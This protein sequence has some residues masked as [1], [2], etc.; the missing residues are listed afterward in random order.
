M[1][2]WLSR[3]ISKIAEAVAR[4][5]VSAEELARA[6]LDRIQAQNDKLGAFL[7]ISADKA[8][9]QARAVD[10]KRARKEPLGKLAGV[11][12]GLKDALCTEGV[13]TTCASKILMR[14]GQGFRPPFDATVVTRLK[15][16]DAVLPGKCNMDEF[17]MGSSTENSAFY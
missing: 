3:P 8:L 7:A 1:Q 14:G 16:A 9:A 10:A 6:S 2:D 4:G 15:G 13:A 12:I 5:D 11:P 17:A